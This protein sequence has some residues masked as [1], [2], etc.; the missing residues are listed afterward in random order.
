MARVILKHISGSRANEVD[1]FP[2][3]GF[4]GLL[5]GRSPSAG[6]RYD[7]DR[8]AMVSREHARLVR[9]PADPSRFTLLDL[10]SR[11]GTYV[12]KKRIVGSA[13]L[14]PGDVI[15]LGPGG[16]ELAFGLD[17][18]SDPSEAAGTPASGPAGASGGE[19]GADGDIRTSGPEGGPV[20]REAP[21]ST[22]GGSAGRRAVWAAGLVV[23]AAVA[24]AIP[25]YLSGRRAVGGDV[26]VAR[27]DK[28]AAGEAAAERAAGAVVRIETEWSLVAVGSGRPVYHEYYVDSGDAGKAGGKNSFAIP[29]VPVFVQLSDGTIEPSLTLRPGAFGQ[30]KPIG[31]RQTGSGFVSDE[32]HI[33]TSGDVVAPWLVPYTEFPAGPGL[34]FKLGETRFARLD[35][36]PAGWMPRAARVLDRKVLP[37]GTTLEARAVRV[38][39]RWRGG[40]APVVAEPVGR[41]GPLG[42]ALLAV[43][44][45]QM[46]DA[47]DASERA[48]GAATV[49]GPVLI[50]GWENAARIVTVHGLRQQGA[51][52]SA[53]ARSL[54]GGPVFDDRGRLIGIYH[55]GPAGDGVDTIIPLAEAIGSLQGTRPR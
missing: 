5:M 9:D 48:R 4:Q 13:I 45:Q 55:A 20:T 26:D 22:R 11:N 38:V 24:I 50:V 29:P 39:V 17:L 25:A 32:G 37:T 43:V 19:R 31:G 10:D 54:T 3:A 46:P 41:P 18:G 44:G 7:P 52:V 21:T 35:R 27:Q 53:A 36:A 12:N 8:D 15:Q 47:V 51:V 6:V 23:A 34:L 14:A 42:A 49:N 1:Q 2:L 16:P 28:A 33:L 40:L 30:N